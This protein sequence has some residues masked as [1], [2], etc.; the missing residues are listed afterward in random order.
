MSAFQ[1]YELICDGLGCTA[2]CNI[3]EATALETRRKAA[4]IGWTCRTLPPGP[5]HQLARYVDLCPIHGID[6][7]SDPPLAGEPLPA[8]CTDEVFLP[9]DVLR[10]IRDCL[11][12]RV[13]WFEARKR[14]TPE[15]TRRALIEVTEA[16][17]F[18]AGGG[19]D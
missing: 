5:G 16:I 13:R 10:E 14:P 4:Q 19:S 12:E 7:P 11:A 8:V 17:N 15:P 18:A 1:H 6:A 2:T 9:V 3:G